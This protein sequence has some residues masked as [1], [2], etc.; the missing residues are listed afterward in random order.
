MMDVCGL[1]TEKLE[2]VR[3]QGDWKLF[4]QISKA[5]SVFDAATSG[6]I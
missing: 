4:S 6:G 3:C 1:E 5:S 2:V